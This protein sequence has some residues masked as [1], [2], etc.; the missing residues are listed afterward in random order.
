MEIDEFLY[1]YV[2]TT[3]SE[4]S[5][6]LNDLKAHAGADKKSGI[7]VTDT[8]SG[9]VYLIFTKGEAQGAV[10]IDRNGILI[11]DKAVFHLKG[12][13]IF[14]F[15]PVDQ[16]VI[17]QFVLCCRI[18]D[19]S[20]LTRNLSPNIP[21]IERRNE[22]MGSFGVRIVKDNV[23]QTGIH[24]SVRKQGRVVGSDVT[25]QDGRAYFKILFGEYDVV[26][27]DRERK[28][29]IFPVKVHSGG[30]EETIDLK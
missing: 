4:G 13:E 29:R 2:G 21:V 25:T 17:E 1:K 22:G 14:S 16:S 12:G 18:F 23:P 5:F 20:H 11:G 10:E 15:H 28:I 6:R 19:Q 24:V 27:M 30:R 8:G 9:K 26:V 3:Q 7:A